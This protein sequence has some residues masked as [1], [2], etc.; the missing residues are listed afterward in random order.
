MKKHTP[1]MVRGIVTK[2]QQLF[3]NAD[4]KEDEIKLEPSVA[5]GRVDG[6]TPMVW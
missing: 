1:E 5:T 4:G 6:S 2:L 3:K